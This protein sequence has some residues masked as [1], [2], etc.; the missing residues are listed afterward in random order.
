MSVDV[1][2]P[3]VLAWNFEKGRGVG[4]KRSKYIQYLIGRCRVAQ[5]SR[6]ARRDRRAPLRCRRLQVRQAARGRWHGDDRRRC[7]GRNRHRRPPRPRRRGR[8]HLRGG[9]RQNQRP[10]LCLRRRLRERL[11]RRRRLLQH[12]L[13]PGLHDLHGGESGGTCVGIEPGGKPRTA[14]ACVAAAAASCG[15]DGTCDGAGGCRKH[16]AGTMCKPGTCEGDAVVGM[17]SC[18]GMGRCKPGATVICVPS[19]CNPSDGVLL[20]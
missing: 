19:S 20:R 13:H 18:D 9:E 12:R 2:V 16:A 11:L 5:S 8:G 7:R 14:S 17:H 1:A 15:L 4:G 6:A 3:A 10:G